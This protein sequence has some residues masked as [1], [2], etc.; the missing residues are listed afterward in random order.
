[1][2]QHGCRIPTRPAWSLSQPRQ[3]RA[4]LSEITVTGSL[5]FQQIILGKIFP[6]EQQEL[7]KR[8][9]TGELFQKTMWFIDR[10]KCFSPIAYDLCKIGSK[11]KNRTRLF[12]KDPDCCCVFFTF[13]CIF[14]SPYK[15]R[16]LIRVLIYRSFKLFLWSLRKYICQVMKRIRKNKGTVATVK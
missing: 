9:L 13:L 12:Y 3:Q 6:R 4:A 1:M 15:N 2:T 10:L 8:I 11:Q 16:L 14:K 5:H 7:F